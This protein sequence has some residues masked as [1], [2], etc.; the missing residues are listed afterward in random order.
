MGEPDQAGS[1]TR[2]EFLR[3]GTL[4]TG[5]AAAWALEERLALEPV[6]AAAASHSPAP[7]SV[8]D[9][10]NQ[11]EHVIVIYLENHTF[12]NLYGLFPGAN[13]L[14]PSEARIP[15]ITRDGQLYAALP[16][17]LI[18]FADPT[19]ASLLPRLESGLAARLATE[20]ATQKGIADPRFPQA[21]PNEPF[22]L[23]P[24]VPNNELVGSPIH[25]F[26]QYQ[27]QV[28]GGKMDR[29]V[30]WGDSGG[31]PMGYYN[32]TELPLFP[33]AHDYT[34]CDNFFTAAFGGSFLNHIWLVAARTPVW[35][36]APLDIVAEPTYDGEGRLVGLARD[37]LVTPDGYAVNTGVEGVYTPHDPRIP[38][39]HLLPPQTFPT[40]GD[41]LSAAGISWA[42]YVGGWDNAL[43]GH[44][45]QP[46]P[47]LPAAQISSFAYFAPYGPDSPGRR[48]HI[49]D[50]TAFLPDLFG[51]GLP[52]VVFLKPTTPFDAHPGY[53]V[54]QL[55]EQHAVDLVEAIRASRYWPRVA[56]IITYDDF[57]GWYDHVAPPVVD[58]WGPGGRV[59]A[60][61]ISPRARRGYVDHTRYDTTSILKLIETRW[62]L[63]L[64]SSRDAAA[65]DLLNAFDFAA[66]T[67]APY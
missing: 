46:L 11:I 66:D 6:S 15:Q 50:A 59:P 40:I 35:P 17:P 61:V 31:L 25:R 36:N 10:L 52:A 65:Q 67:G 57:G 44:P 20:I 19:I 30:A 7:E 55:A 9:E 34:L 62:S 47:L 8:R 16:Q 4:V 21:L 13:G 18:S 51:G 33:Y 39:D 63:P 64:L 49:K 37:G 28:H 56:I 23:D 38:P 45:D 32:T 27:L 43:A 29:Y 12:D 1:I 2:R 24:Y 5:T 53:S 58:R 54:L 60:L 41:R 42:E 48:E 22:L 14:L 26:Y 3:R